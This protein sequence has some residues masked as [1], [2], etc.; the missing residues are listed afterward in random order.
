MRAFLGLFSN[1]NLI[2]ILKKYWKVLKTK[3]KNF[4][5]YATL[6]APGHVIL[7]TFQTYRGQKWFS[8]VKCHP[9]LNFWFLIF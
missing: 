2:C 9:F 8:A 5:L 6:K 4:T 7:F 1:D 3:L